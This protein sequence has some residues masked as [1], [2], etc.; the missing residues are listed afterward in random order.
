MAASYGTMRAE[1]AILLCLLIVGVSLDGVP[2]PPAVRPQGNLSNL[3]PHLHSCEPLA[4]SNHV[5]DY[6]ASALHFQARLFPFGQIFEGKGPSY[7]PVF[8]R[9]A[10]DSSPPC[11]S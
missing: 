2:D 6:P 7:D 5:S 1:F 8:V 3:V 10:T 9:Q 11:F 4:A